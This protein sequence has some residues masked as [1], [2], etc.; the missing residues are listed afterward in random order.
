MRSATCHRRC[1]YERVQLR[2]RGNERVHRERDWLARGPTRYRACRC[3]AGGSLLVLAIRVVQ[4]PK[5]TERVHGAKA[6][7]HASSGSH[8][9]SGRVE[10]AVNKLLG[11]FHHARVLFRR[12]VRIRG[13]MLA[14]RSEEHTSELQS[15]VNLVCRLL[16]EKKKGWLSGKV[17]RLLRLF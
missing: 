6:T 17:E 4:A 8:L 12:E 7:A 5:M 10:N 13:Q 3:A 15:H 1:E 11:E 9:F 16:L 2:H 14:Q